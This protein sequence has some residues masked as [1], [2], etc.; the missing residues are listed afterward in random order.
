MNN[1]ATRVETR[2]WTDE[3]LARVRQALPMGLLGVAVGTAGVIGARLVAHAHGLDNSYTVRDPAAITDAFWF[4]GLQ[5][6]LGVMLWIAAASCCLLGAALLRGVP[7]ARRSARFLLA[8]GLF[9]LWLGLDDGFM[10]HDEVLPNWQGIPEIALYALYL[11]LMGAYLV[12][13]RGTIFRTKYPLLVAAGVGMGASLVIDQF[14][15]S[16]FFEDGTKF[17]GIVF[18]AAYLFDATLTLVR[19][20]IPGLMPAARRT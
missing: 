19:Q 10:L 15:N 8:S 7:G 4:V 14:F 11:A 16:H 9:S 2:T 12:Y 17:Y 5:S 20:E 18:W 3:V 6:N 1:T 13:F